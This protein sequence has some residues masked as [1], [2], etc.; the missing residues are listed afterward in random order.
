[1]ENIEAYVSV[2]TDDGQMELHRVGN[3]LEIYS[4]PDTRSVCLITQDGE[5]DLQFQ[6]VT[7][8]RVDEA[9]PPVRFEET[10]TGVDIQNLDNRN[11]V[12]LSQLTSSQK[13]SRGESI[14]VD[15]DCVIEPGVNT[16]LR[17][18]VE[19]V[20]SEDSSASSDDIPYGMILHLCE[21]FPLTVERAPEEANKYGQVLF[22]VI[23]DNPIDSQTYEES[24]TTLRGIVNN[25]S[26]DD[27]TEESR[28]ISN[29]QEVANSIKHLYARQR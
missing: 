22:Q 26:E 20:H 4:D 2:L 19:E 10:S 12:I 27:L 7:L 3:S 17:L 21:T 23:R 11:D 14:H 28:Y 29:A 5:V 15:S 25:L 24:K 1:M 13:I 16:K 9:G 8:S 6:D 18:S